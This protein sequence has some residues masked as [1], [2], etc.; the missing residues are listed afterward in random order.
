MCIR[1]R[2]T[3]S[4]HLLNEDDTVTLLDVTNDDQNPDN[5]QGIVR[6]SLTE[7]EFEID[8]TSGSLDP[9]KLYKVQR[10]LNYAKSSNNVL[11]ITDF[12]SDIQN[13]YTSKDNKEVYVTCG[14][15]P[16]YEIFSDTRKK[17]FISA[18]PEF[19][20]NVDHVTDII[21]INNHNFLQGEL[22]RYAPLVS[23]GAT[24]VGLDTGSKYAVTK[25][26]NNRIRLSR[27]V[28]DVAT[29]KYISISGVGNTTTHELIPADLTGKNVKYQNFLRKFPITPEPKEVEL[30][31]KNEPIGMLING[32]ELVSNQSG[33]SLHYGP[34]EHIDVESG[35]DDYD[36]ITPPDIHISDNVGTGATAYA[37]VEGSFK[38]IEVVSG[39]YDLKQVPNVAITGGNGQGATASARLKATR[40]SRVF[41]AKT[42]VAITATGVPGTITFIDDHLFFDGESVVYEKSTAN[43]AVGGLVDKSVYYV[44]KISEKQISLA[45]KFDDAVAGINSVT[46]GNKSL[47]SHKFTSTTFR[48]VLDKIYVDNA[49]SGYSLSLIHI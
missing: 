1:D 19:N 37:V 7:L 30:E 25:V 11:G 6:R 20:S 2:T 5:V 46:I 26:D 49:G 47:G 10:A 48:N 33:D 16:S 28:A 15:L 32:V 40:N 39:G 29:G 27:S 8:I 36:V 34:I 18:H 12:V 4:P 45:T 44:N 3:S 17:E 42:D 35:G 9:T 41:D 43:A 21:T 14:S 22:V 31:L 13:T 38:S 24:V 23:P